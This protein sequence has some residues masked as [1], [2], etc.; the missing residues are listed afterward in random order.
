MRMI[1]SVGYTHSTTSALSVKW[2]NHVSQ[3]CSQRT[4]RNYINPS[5]II[6]CQRCSYSFKYVY[7]FSSS[8]MFTSIHSF[9]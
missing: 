3:H 1:L 8:S 9:I 6:Y 7:V 2:T 5:E 4:S